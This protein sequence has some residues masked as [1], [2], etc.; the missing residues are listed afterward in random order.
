MCRLVAASSLILLG[1]RVIVDDGT[2][3]KGIRF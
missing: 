1:L 2:D 3:G